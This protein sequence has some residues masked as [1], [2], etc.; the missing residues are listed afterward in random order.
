MFKTA[1]QLFLVLIP[2]FCFSQNKKD[3][4]QLFFE[5]DKSGS[6]QNKA[7]IDSLQKT[8]KGK[9]YN[10]W[11]YGYADFLHTDDYNQ[12]LSQQRA[13]WVKSVLQKNSSAPQMSI[14]ACEGR[15]EKNS[16]D[17]GSGLG[18]PFQR[19]VDLIFELRPANRVVDTRPQKPGPAPEPQKAPRDTGSI[20]VKELK[21]RG[22]V[23]LEGL[24]FIPGRHTLMPSSIPV[25]ERLLNTMLKNPDLKIEIQG[26]ICCWDYP[27]DGYDYDSDDMNLSLNRAKEV[28]DYLLKHGVDEDRMSYKGF[29]STRRRAKEV[30]PETE[31]MNRRVEIRVME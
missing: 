24:S 1:Q 23:A 7:R 14:L 6:S 11:L 29:G 22:K 12:T 28:Y 15:G 4:L 20:N 25:L 17:H 19:R 10:V 30:S 27:T 18:E 16:A 9:V 5:I 31:Q 2:F 26:H 3:T 13:E 21:E 8:L